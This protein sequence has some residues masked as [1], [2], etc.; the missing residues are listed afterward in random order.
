[1]WSSYFLLINKL[2]SLYNAFRDI[3]VLKWV[4]EISDFTEVRSQFLNPSTFML[5]GVTKM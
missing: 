5:P 4:I 1:M 3:I 2:D